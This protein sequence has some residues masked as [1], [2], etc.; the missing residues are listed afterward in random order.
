MFYPY[1]NQ[2]EK[3]PLC[4]H[5]PSAS[6]AADTESV[7]HVELAQFLGGSSRKGLRAAASPALWRGARAV[8]AG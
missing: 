4:Q 6:H 1:E 3:R 8:R 7:L 5:R 2:K